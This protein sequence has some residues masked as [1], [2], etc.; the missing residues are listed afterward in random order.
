MGY[1]IRMKP[2]PMQ[3]VAFGSITGSYTTLATVAAATRIVKVVNNTNGL[4]L[5]SW[6]GDGS[7]DNDVLP[8]N[9]FFLYDISSNKINDNGCFVSEGTVFS[10]KYSGSAPSSG[11]VYFV[12]LITGVF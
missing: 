7:T 1:L 10:L 11:S 4:I 8:A 5:L 3:S 2:N 6:N 9:S 12:S